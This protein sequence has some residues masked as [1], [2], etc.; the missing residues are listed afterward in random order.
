M[1]TGD[2]TVTISDE[3]PWLEDSYDAMIV[4]KLMIPF[5]VIDFGKE[6]KER[7]VDYMFSEYKVGRTSNPDILCNKQIKFDLFLKK[8][9]SLMQI[10]LQLDTTLL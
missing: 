5:Q 8:H 3:V 10:I 7:I 9:W 1:K 2:E 4:A 6:Y